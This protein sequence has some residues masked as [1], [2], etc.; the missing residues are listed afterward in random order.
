MTDEE[1]IA[2]LEQGA[3]EELSPAMVKLIR[4][5]LGESA[6]VRT[7]L[8]E[9]IYVEQYLAGAIG[10]DIVS[11]E[12]LVARAARLRAPR[13]LAKR[14]I[15]VWI[16]CLAMAS[17]GLAFAVRP[18][19]SRKASG[20]AAQSSGGPAAKDSYA[21]APQAD[22]LE[23]TSP[24]PTD[25]PDRGFPATPQ[26]NSVKR[27][28]KV[29]RKIQRLPRRPRSDPRGRLPTSFLRILDL[30]AIRRAKRNWRAGSRPRRDKP[31]DSRSGLCGSAVAD[32]LMGGSSF[33]T[34]GLQTECC[35]WR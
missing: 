27:R 1:L 30:A 19:M 33:A 26:R 28:P 23:T 25:G 17:I 18:F 12:Q 11:R 24:S 10:G 13:T 32:F 8:V 16:A 34:P 35:G 22:P 3:P 31:I 9:R 4:A 15:A 2:Q 6:A 14:T 20:V 5:R 21:A 7:A 29:R